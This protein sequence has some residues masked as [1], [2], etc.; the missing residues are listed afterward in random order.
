MFGTRT[1]P[2]RHRTTET[3]Q[4]G[5]STCSAGFSKSYAESQS[6]AR[7]FECLIFADSPQNPAFAL[8]SSPLPLPLT[9]ASRS[10]AVPSARPPA[11]TPDFELFICFL[12]RRSIT[13][14]CSH[15]VTHE[16]LSLTRFSRPF[17]KLSRRDVLDELRSCDARGG[18]S[19]RAPHWIIA[20]LRRSLHNLLYVFR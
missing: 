3:G 4:Y 16:S 8:T 9:A 19:V 7:H 6:K 12:R 11:R 13:T 17:K 15:S 14:R 18:R 5:S 2:G 20:V 10:L 1:H